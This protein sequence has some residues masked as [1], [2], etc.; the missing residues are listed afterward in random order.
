MHGFCHIEIPT[1]DALKSKEFY[2]KIF[3]WEFNE[4]GGEYVMFKTPEGI[5]GGF[6]T[7]RKPCTDG[8]GL[9]I[10]VEDI[11]KKLAE[12]EEAVG[13]TITPKT[14]ISDEFGFFALFLDPLGNGLGIW[15]KT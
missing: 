14:K 8:A 2:G 13:K 7:E 6:T 15:S 4:M 3:G 1:T 5:G 10:E 12:I 11:E 9:Y